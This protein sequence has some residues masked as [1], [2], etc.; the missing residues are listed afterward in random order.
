MP[1]EFVG[2]H[3]EWNLGS[4]GGWDYQRMAQEIGKFTWERIKKETG[5]DIELDFDCPILNPVPGFAQ[6][7]LRSHEDNYG[8][9]KPHIAIISEKETLEKGGENIHIVEYLNSI[10]GIKAT[11][12]DPSR[13]ELKDGNI[14]LN[15]EP[16]TVI[17]QDMSNRIILE[18]K[19]QH[20]VKPLL[21]A[22]KKGI[23]VNPRGMEIIGAKGVFE[24]ITSE[25]K[26]LISDTT[27]MRT[28]WTRRFFKRATTGPSG[29]HISNLVEW[30]RENWQN[31]I[32]KPVRGYPGK[33]V[34]I[35]F[36]E[37]DVEGSIQKALEAGDY[38]IQPLVP[39]DLWQEEFPCVDREHKKVILKALQTN[40]RCLITDT[41]V[42]GFV[43]RFG[44]IPTKIGQGGGV[45]ASAV[46]RSDIPLRDAVARINHLIARQ[47]FDFLCGLQD[48]TDT[49]SI[50]IGNTYLRRPIMNTLRPRIIT[51]SH[52]EDIMLYG[53]NL[54]QDAMAVE[55]LW[56]EDK[57]SEYVQI[58]KEEEEIAKL[59]PWHGRSGLMAADGLFGFL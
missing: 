18:L 54:W 33:G 15:N 25:Y 38:I 36:K 11:L 24:A 17:F 5:L 53:Q 37:S 7:L 28:P 42:I 16:V 43:T 27:I 19:K 26:N 46:L 30:A 31:I 21:E 13:L 58:N 44:G 55:G 10:E 35:G 20:S 57:L 56:L 6:M 1:K 41:G 2:F 12:A 8:A 40:F 14:Y 29:T 51:E 4:P 9:Q 49:K 50:T 23:V 59:A 32:L 52:I 22:I 39:L 48:E 34:I 47:S 45:Q 3:S